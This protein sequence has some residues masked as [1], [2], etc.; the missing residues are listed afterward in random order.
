MWEW[1]SIKVTWWFGVSSTSGMCGEFVCCDG[2]VL[3]L[4]SKNNSNSI[5][6]RKYM[7]HLKRYFNSEKMKRHL[8][9]VDLWSLI[10]R[11]SRVF[12]LFFLF[13]THRTT[14]VHSNFAWHLI[15]SWKGHSIGELIM[16]LVTFQWHHLPLPF[17]SSHSFRCSSQMG[18]LSLHL[19]RSQSGRMRILLC[20]FALF[21]F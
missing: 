11:I 2:R 13:R 21:F 12:S 9:W 5:E 7:E 18:S 20:L 16:S 4:R 10:F 14:T 3:F 6:V 15:Q 19:Q 17:L 8:K 1:W